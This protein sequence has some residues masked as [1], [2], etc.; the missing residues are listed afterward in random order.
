MDLRASRSA[1][2]TMVRFLSLHRMMPMDEF[3]SFL[4]GL[5]HA[6]FAQQLHQSA[7]RH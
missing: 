1:Y 4:Q 6:D 3:S 2:S 5:T 7:L